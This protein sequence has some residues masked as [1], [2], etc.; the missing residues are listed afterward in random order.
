MGRLALVEQDR[1][2][3]V[4]AVDDAPHVDIQQPVPGLQL[5][6]PG[7]SPNEHPG[8]VADDV[9]RPEAGQ[10]PT[11]EVG[12]SAGVGHVCRYGEDLGAGVGC[13]SL[14]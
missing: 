10:D 11:A 7:P 14:G 4:D 8:V 1:H 9:D 13:H 5:D 12:D 3:R 6:L 2:E